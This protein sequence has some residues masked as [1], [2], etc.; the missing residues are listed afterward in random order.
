MMSKDL[1]IRKRTLNEYKQ[2][3]RNANKG[4]LRGSAMHEKSI[5]QFGAAR[6]AVAD[7]N[8]V[9]L[10][11]NH[12][13]EQLFAAGI[14]DVI[15]IETDG[16]QFVV[17]KR[18]DLDANTERGRE[19][20]LYDNRVGELNLSWDAQS[21]LADINDGVD[22][23]QFFDQDELDVLLNQVGDSAWSDALGGL[24]SGDKSPF[25]Q[26]TFTLSN[27]QAGVVAEAISKAK[28]TSDF[29]GTGN[30]NSN[31]NALWRICDAYLHS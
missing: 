9:F 6:S 23:A 22:L 14:T 27:E 25:Q 31:G 11:G 30:E 17:V 19:Y 4:T 8:D 1:K 18:S 5:E 12:T 28:S 26:M 15:E 13:A 3:Q 16:K 24:P 7:V 2:L 20:S 21:L 29:V 10:A